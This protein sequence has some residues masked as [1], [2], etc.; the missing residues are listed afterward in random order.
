MSMI[1]SVIPPEIIDSYN[2]AQSLLNP[3]KKVEEK[4]PDKKGG[5]G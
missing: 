1:L 4:K 5:R 3:N 2:V